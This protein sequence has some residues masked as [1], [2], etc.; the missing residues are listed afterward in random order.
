MVS[1]TSLASSF[2]TQGVF[3][4]VCL[5]ACA[6]PN[7]AS[8]CRRC[9]SNCN[10]RVYVSLRRASVL[11][12]EKSAN[13]R[14]KRS[15][16]GRFCELFSDGKKR[17][18]AGSIPQQVQYERMHRAGFWICFLLGHSR[19]INV[20]PLWPLALICELGLIWHCVG[21]FIASLLVNSI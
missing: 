5:R 8:S 18:S 2:S 15:A 7:R 19:S 13:K 21:I 9:F 1:D 12:R 16:S 10:R 3:V 20:Y 4:R 17:E 11:P 14:V 6:Q